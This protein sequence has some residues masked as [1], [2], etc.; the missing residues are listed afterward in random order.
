[1]VST[2]SVGWT[3]NDKTV[4]REF[5]SKDGINLRQSIK[6]C[7]MSVAVRENRRHPVKLPYP[8]IPC[9]KRRSGNEGSVGDMSG[10]A[11]AKECAFDKETWLEM[12][13]GN[14]E[15]MPTKMNYLQQREPNRRRMKVPWRILPAAS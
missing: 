10:A 15:L 7:W 12:N 6:R 1:M 8:Y 14:A 9:D 4:T 2:I 5:L 11:L 13:C 3:T